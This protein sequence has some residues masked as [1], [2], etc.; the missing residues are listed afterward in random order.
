[1]LFRSKM[2]YNPAKIIH[3]DRG[4]L[5]VGRPADITIIDPEREYVI[6]SN[7]F[8]SKGKNTPFNGRKVKGMVKV[9]ICDG[10]I[11]YIEE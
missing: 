2:S 8:E 11:A 3:S 1:M 5:E 7:K 10:E 4:R 9:T 6:D